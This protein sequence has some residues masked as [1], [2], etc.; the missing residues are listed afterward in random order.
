[1]KKSSTNNIKK[2]F[3]FIFLE[4]S[5]KIVTVE[6][7]IYLHGNAISQLPI[8]THIYI[9][10]RYDMYMNM[11]YKNFLVA[12]IAVLINGSVLPESWDNFA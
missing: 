9:C 6:K 3:K 10:T 12:Y 7:D 2:I 4:P 5:I 11:K 1:M 8:T